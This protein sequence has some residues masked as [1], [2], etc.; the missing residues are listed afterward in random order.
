MGYF[1]NGIEGDMYEA[2]YC[3]NCAHNDAETGCPVMLCHI[4]YAYEE[5]NNRGKT[6]AANMLDILIPR[7]GA[8]NGKCKMHLPI[9]RGGK[10]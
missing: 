3:G 8:F 1:S 10:G 5:C 4:L 7:V 2:Q 9:V 6:N